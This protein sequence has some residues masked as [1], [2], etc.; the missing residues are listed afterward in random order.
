M[1]YECSVC[2][3]VYDEDAE[4]VPWNE[5]PD[6]WECPV[7][8]ADKSYF[9]VQGKSP[10]SGAEPPT[11][12]A[13]GAPSLDGYLSE[14]RRSS[15]EVESDFAAIQQMAITGKSIIEPMRTRKPVVSWDEILVMGAQ[16]ASLPR[17][18]DD[19][20]TTRTVIGPNAKQPLVMSTPVF[21]SHMSFG[22]LSREAKIASKAPAFSTISPLRTTLKRSSSPWDIFSTASKP[23]IRAEPLRLWASRKISSSRSDRPGSF[24]NSRSDSLSFWRCSSLSKIS[25]TTQAYSVTII[26]TGWNFDR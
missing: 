15:D 26:N 12:A 21:V 7:C 5:L 13:T 4:G 2:G 23:I 8:N 1:K 19:P 25:F 14:W 20:V 16:L 24:S 18:E 3:Y 10:D 6:D 22:A 17:N 11:A 9:E